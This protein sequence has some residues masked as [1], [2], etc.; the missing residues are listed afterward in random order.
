MTRLFRSAALALSLAAALAASGCSAK[1]P[2]AAELDAIVEALVKSGKLEEAIGKVFEARSARM[3]EEAQAQAAE[4][5]KAADAK[6]A[7]A[8]AADPSR[9]HVYGDPKARYS[10]IVYSDFECPFCK[11]F[12]GT[13]EKAAELSQTGANVIFRHYPLAMHNPLAEREHA[14]A[15]CAARQAGGKAFFPFAN[16]LFSLTQGNSRGVPGGESALLR[17]AAK[18]GAG[19]AAALRRCAESPETLERIRADIADGMAAGVSGTPATVA[20]DNQTGAS[21]LVVGAQPAEAV[22]NALRELAG[23][24]PAR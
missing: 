14:L 4:A 16:E 10:L 1:E 13:P 6:A 2:S 12:A 9:D 17:L 20:R 8:R 23:A 15:L 5:Q 7:K 21:R 3:R 22:A 11:R 24:A 19:D 18:H